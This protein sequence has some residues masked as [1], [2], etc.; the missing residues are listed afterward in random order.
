MYDLVFDTCIVSRS[1]VRLTVYCCG[2]RRHGVGRGEKGVGQHKTL[3]LETKGGSERRN[4]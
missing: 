1:G 3:P 2:Y 4:G